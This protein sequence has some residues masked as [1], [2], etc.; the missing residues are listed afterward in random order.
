MPIKVRE[1]IKDKRTDELAQAKAYEAF[2][3]ALD[4]E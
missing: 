2:L 1:A 3:S 4:L